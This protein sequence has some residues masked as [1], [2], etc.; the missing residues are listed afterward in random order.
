MTAPLDHHCGLH[1]ASRGLSCSWL[2][3]NSR[4]GMVNEA[5]R[6]LPRW[7]SPLAITSSGRPTQ[8]ELRRSATPAR[9]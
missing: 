8:G 6:N 3:N 9:P 1:L 2:R 7:P 5:D 4:P